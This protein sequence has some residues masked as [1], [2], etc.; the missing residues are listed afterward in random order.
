MKLKN[1]IGACGA[2]MYLFT[3]TAALAAPQTIP[4]PADLDITSEGAS[5]APS[6]INH[7]KSPYFTTPDFYNMKSNKNLTILSH[8]PTYQQSRENTCGPAAALTVLYYFGKTDETEMSLAKEM[9]TQPYPIGTNP[10]DMVNYFKQ[11]GWH[12]ESNLT[13][14]EFATYEDF[15]AFVHEQLKKNHPIMVENVEWGGHWRVIIGYDT[16]G[17]DNML[18]DVLILADPY[19]TCDHAQDGYAVQNATKFY[20]MWFDHSMLPKDQANQPFILTYPEK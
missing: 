18:D 10:G 1:L 13:H 17:T 9:K 11:L 7:A 12:T 5:S 8:Y 16:M 4:Y 15:A 19:D 3:G 2:A 6:E 14:G 20:A